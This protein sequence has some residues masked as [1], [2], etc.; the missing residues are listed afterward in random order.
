MAGW[1]NLT[2]EWKALAS[3][4]IALDSNLFPGLKSVAVKD[5]C[6]YLVIRAQIRI[7]DTALSYD[8]S[9]SSDLHE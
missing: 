5:D 4:G 6:M 3:S 9:A 8:Y 7:R 2:N 1:G